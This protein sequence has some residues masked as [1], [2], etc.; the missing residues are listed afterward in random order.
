MRRAWELWQSVWEMGRVLRVLGRVERARRKRGPGPLVEA[1]RQEGSRAVQ[2]DEQ[3]RRCLRRAIRWVDTWFGRNC[4]RRVLLEIALDRGAAQEPVRFGL[5]AD[6]SSLA[7]HAWLG[8]DET[9]K[10]DMT[11][12]L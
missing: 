9:G 11:I 6:G 7:G 12:R 5:K 10:F 3:G 4:Y 8:D 2:R 1:L